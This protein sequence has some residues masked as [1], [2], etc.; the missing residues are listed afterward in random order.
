MRL[1]KSRFFLIAFLPN[2]FFIFL[3]VFLGSISGKLNQPGT[4]GGIILADSGAYP[5]FIS[6]RNIFFVAYLVIAGYLIY[7]YIKVKKKNG[8]AFMRSCIIVITGI[9]LSMFAF[10]FSALIID[11]YIIFTNLPIR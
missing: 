4:Y 5:V 6:L 2:L 10:F 3:L 1:L 11:F 9:S 8:K 7:E